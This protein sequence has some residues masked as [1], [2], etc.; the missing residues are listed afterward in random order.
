MQKLTS[1]KFM[2]A[3][4]AVAA[5]A[6]ILLAYLS[7][8]LILALNATI[9]SRTD[10]IS[11][12]DDTLSML[13]DCETGQRG[14]LLTGDPDY[15]QPYNDARAP[16]GD[17]LNKV[18][19]LVNR[20]LIAQTDATRLHSLARERLDSLQRSI[21]MRTAGDVN[22]AVD[23]LNSN[24]GKQIMD[25]LRSLVADMVQGERS[26]LRAARQRSDQVTRW[27]SWTY[28]GL[29]MGVLA[30]LASAFG[31]IRREM[32][33]SDAAARETQRQRDLLAVTL[34]SIGDAVIV[35]DGAGRITFLNG[36]AEKLT[37]WTM[38]EAAGQPHAAVFRILSE[39]TQTPAPDPVDG[40]LRD[41]VVVG[42]ANH[43]LLVGRNGAQ[44]PIDHIG[45]P[46][47]ETDGAIRGVILVFRDFSEHKQAETKL[48]AAYE[49]LESAGK[50]KDRF[51]A[52]LSHE[53]R[54]PLTP[55]LATLANWESDPNLPDNLRGQAQMLRRNVELE[56]RLIDDLLDLTRIAK[57]KVPIQLETI[58]VHQTL[59]GVVTMNGSEINTR[60]IQVSMLLGAANHYVMADVARLQQIFWNVL[61]NAVKFTPEGGRIT[62]TTAN[63]IPGQLRIQF[64]DNGIG[65]SPETLQ[66]I[67]RPFEQGTLDMPRRYAGLGLGMAIAKALTDAQS[68]TITAASNGLGRGST[69]VIA[70]PTIAAPAPRAPHTQSSPPT[71]AGR[72]LRIL[73]VEDHADTASVLRRLLAGQG[74][75]V[76]T[77]ASVAQA[78]ALIR[79]EPFDILLSDIGLPDGTGIDLIR[80]AR[81]AFTAPAI[82]L[83][84]FG[85]EDD[86]A[87]CYDAGFNVHLTKP[88][89]FQKLVSVI[90]EQAQPHDPIRPAA[91]GVPPGQ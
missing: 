18:D 25:Q 50:A 30:I 69:F 80:Q 87:R 24:Q 38:A 36:V 33:A 8:Q 59:E 27:R 31:R 68:G 41:G 39:D 3:T 6:S 81:P 88:V 9:E 42:P 28:A 51:I 5:L 84:G 2:F 43:T 1:L 14:Y 58:D 78:L 61:K 66:R 79:A 73:L 13:K 7:A 60:R 16:L 37:G 26:S 56:A 22:G 12:L 48:K 85:M 35:T 55:V 72:P 29:C 75:I 83:T 57:G 10:A 89:N 52:T 74:H 53:L 45:A 15:L 20:G 90:R 67:F 46:I 23:L 19:D 76:A 64:D 47:R 32:S 71:P 11:L 54:T 17:D 62:I 40:V 65:M 77:A 4:T 82:A 63:D 70:F 49:S 91:R 86:V 44:T 21:D 34:A